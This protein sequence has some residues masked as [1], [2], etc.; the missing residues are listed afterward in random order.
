MAET[1]DG[2]ALLHHG[3]R[4][5][6]R[7]EAKGLRIDVGYLKSA[8]KD[9][10]TK[11]LGMESE[12]QESDVMKAWRKKFE[13]ATK[14]ASRPQLAWVC[15]NV[16]G[17]ELDSTPAGGYRTDEIS[18][19]VYDNP[20]IK[21]YLDVLK[22]RK[23]KNTYLLGILREVDSDGILH[24]FFNLQTVQTYR[25]SS[26]EPNFQNMP[27]RDPEMAQLIRRAFIPRKGNVL[28]E[29]DY[30]GIEVRIAACYHKDPVMLQYINDPT[31]DMHLDMAAQ[32]YMLPPDEVTKRIRYEAKNKW[33]FP[34]F[35]GSWFVTCAE[36]LWNTICTE[37]NLASGMDLKEHLRLQGIT[38]CGVWDRDNPPGQ[39]TFM[40]HLSLVQDDFWG[41]RFKVY[42][43]WKETCYADYQRNGYIDTLSGFRLSGFMRKNEAINYPVQGAAFHCLLW[44]LI[45]MVLK[46]LPE[47]GLGA[48]IVGQIHDSIFADVP[49]SEE[50]DYCAL[51]KD[52]MVNKMVDAWKWIIVPL[53]VDF[54]VYPESWA[55]ERKE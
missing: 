39:G 5:L 27:I 38:S 16:L 25:S 17:M 33:V 46:E 12:L 51:V 55:N 13:S 42:A 43:K 35:Y 11:L 53:E 45:R 8:I 26:S 15:R 7:V 34:Q 49:V 47:S 54:S 31:K 14:L 21:S 30:G 40:H 32:C 9:T 29:I 6:S 37:T 22:L 52:V 3:A 2:Y 44:S 20:F 10:D 1:L 23:A 36:S 18:L 24:P 28:I 41:R 19:S 48:H 4:A 50:S